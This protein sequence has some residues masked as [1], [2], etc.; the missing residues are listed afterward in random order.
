MVKQNGQGERGQLSLQFLSKTL[1]DRGGPPPQQ[2]LLHLS[3]CALVMN[4]KMPFFLLLIKHNIIFEN[5]ATCIVVSHVAVSHV[6]LR[7]FFR[8]RSSN[9]KFSILLW[10]L[11]L[12]ADDKLIKQVDIPSVLV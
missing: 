12:H 2:L 7:K 4:G 10:V 9:P 3:L 1:G 5:Q 8:K 6:V 11:L